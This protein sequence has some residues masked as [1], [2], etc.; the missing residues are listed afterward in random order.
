MEDFIQDYCNQGTMIEMKQGS[1]PNTTWTHGDLWTTNR[2]R[3]SV[4]RKILRGGTSLVVQGLRLC[5]SNVGGMGF[6]PSGVTTI[7]MPH[8]KKKRKKEK[9]KLLRGD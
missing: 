1:T 5:A 3:G 9:I 4:D 7:H 2:V 8:G 6:I